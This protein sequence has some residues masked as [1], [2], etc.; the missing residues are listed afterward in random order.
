MHCY[1]RQGF[2][3][4]ILSPISGAII[5]FLGEIHVDDIDLI[6]TRPEFTTEKQTQDSAT[7]PGLGHWDLTQQ[8]VPL[9]QRRA[10]G[11][12]QGTSGQM[13]VGHMPHNQT[14]GWRSHYLTIL[15]PQ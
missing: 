14:S 11:Y 2:G 13:V 1:G 10:I 4:R 5:N 8:E 7:P 3:L 12:T 9:T 15:P 6:I